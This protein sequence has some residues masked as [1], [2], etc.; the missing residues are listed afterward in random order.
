MNQYGCNQRRQHKQDDF[1]ALSDNVHSVLLFED[2]DHDAAP[3][4][5]F[6]TSCSSFML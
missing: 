1:P 2:V 6:V 4:R 3:F 5:G